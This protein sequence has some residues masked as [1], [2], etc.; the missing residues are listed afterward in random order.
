[1]VRASR[2]G[3]QRGLW[4]WCR[5]QPLGL[6][7]DARVPLL[8][9]WPLALPISERPA[10]DRGGSQSGAGARDAPAPGDSGPAPT[11]GLWGATRAPAAWRR[12]ARM[13]TLHPLTATPPGTG[14]KVLLVPSPSQWKQSR[15]QT[16]TPL[17]PPKLRPTAPREASHFPP[18][19]HVPRSPAE[20]TGRG[21]VATAKVPPGV[22][23]GLRRPNA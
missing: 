4:I 11:P 5:R 3:S 15:E 9:L 12:Q 10:R 7:P 17:K 1:M 13:L 6:R 23:C 22:R 20:E 19:G 14:S 8:R 16:A 2:P 21:A 18:A